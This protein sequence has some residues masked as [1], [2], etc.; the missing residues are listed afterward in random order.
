MFVCGL[1][2][3]GILFA[4]TLLIGLITNYLF[5]SEIGLN[6]SIAIIYIGSIYYGYKY[7][8]IYGPLLL[9]EDGKALKRL[10]F[11]SAGFCILF[12]LPFAYFK[13]VI[14][15]D[16]NIIILFIIVCLSL[17]MT[18]MNFLSMFLLGRFMNKKI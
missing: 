10:F 9:S 3:G 4:I 13:L 15:S 11:Y 12:W 5:D 8:P 18:A 1:K 14:A 2:H 16:I 17:P 6:I 7:Y